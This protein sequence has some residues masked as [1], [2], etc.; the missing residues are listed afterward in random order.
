MNLIPDYSLWY[1]LEKDTERDNLVL[2]SGDYRRMKW[3]WASIVSLH[4]IIS[5]HFNDGLSRDTKG[6]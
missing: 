5:R 1:F 4:V 3:K 6:W 2:I